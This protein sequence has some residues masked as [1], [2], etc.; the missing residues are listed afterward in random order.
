M[1]HDNSSSIV[2]KTDE[3]KH[4]NKTFGLIDHLF[5]HDI[6]LCWLH[7]VNK[8]EI[9]SNSCDTSFHN[10]HCCALT[11][12]AIFI[13]AFVGTWYASILKYL[14][15]KHSQRCSAFLNVR[16]TLNT[17]HISC[18]K[19]KHHGLIKKTKCYS[20]YNT[21][22]LILHHH[23]NKSSHAQVA[24]VKN[25]PSYVGLSLN[26]FD[27]SSHAQVVIDTIVFYLHVCMLYLCYFI[28]FDRV[29]N[30]IE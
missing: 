19:S 18:G 13:V 27:I 4:T 12:L 30:L 5:L 17:Q 1:P 20:S 14:I 22:W 8:L 23:P 15:C 16:Q 11:R 2:H 7:Q 21:S 29:R 26:N 28:S 6:N 9:T 3:C 24:H 10:I 25:L